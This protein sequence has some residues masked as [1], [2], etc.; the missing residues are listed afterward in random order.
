MYLC[1]DSKPL[2]LLKSG[3][4]TVTGFVILLSTLAFFLFCPL[5]FFHYRIDRSTAVTI[6]RYLSYVLF[7]FLVCLLSVYYIW[8]QCCF[9][10]VEHCI[11]VCMYLKCKYPAQIKAEYTHNGF[12]VNSVSLTDRRDVE[13]TVKS[14]SGVTKFLTFSMVSSLIFSSF[15][16]LFLLLWNVLMVYLFLRKMYRVVV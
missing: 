1:V 11:I 8:S 12:A 7:L 14:C 4:P 9:D 6:C 13:V 15:I 10:F 16:F 5:V 2:I 3:E